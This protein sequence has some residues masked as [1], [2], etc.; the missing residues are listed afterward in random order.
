MLD[1]P[2]KRFLSPQARRAAVEVRR[3]LA[4]QNPRGAPQ[5]FVVRLDDP[6]RFGWEIRKFGGLVLTRSET[7]FGTQLLA[8]EA[9]KRA[10][11]ELA[12]A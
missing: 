10:L 5:V 4:A 9:G 11:T 1:D 8:L 2:K 3:R 12:A 6:K 7:G